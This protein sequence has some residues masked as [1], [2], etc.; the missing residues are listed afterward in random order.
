MAKRQDLETKVNLLSEENSKLNQSMIELN[1]G[2][3]NARAENA[4]LE[5]TTASQNAQ[6]KQMTSVIESIQTLSSQ[7]ISSLNQTLSDT[8]N[9]LNQVMTRVAEYEAI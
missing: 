3:H 2:F 7:K 5:T 1:N 4:K 8:N 9:Q 6:I